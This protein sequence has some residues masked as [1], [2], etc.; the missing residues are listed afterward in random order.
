MVIL[1]IFECLYIIIIDINTEYSNC[2]DG[3]VQL[4]G[5]SNRLEGRVEICINKAWGT[6][7]NNAFSTEDAT[8]VC[9]QLKLPYAGNTITFILCMPS[10]SFLSYHQKY[11]IIDLR[12]HC[13]HYRDFFLSSR[14]Y[15]CT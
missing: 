4:V 5:G 3:D 10:V 6:I 2:S 8:V 1:K 9:N 14:C 12:V 15:C 7:C 13:I 11:H